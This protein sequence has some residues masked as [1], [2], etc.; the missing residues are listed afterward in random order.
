MKIHELLATPDQFCREH[1]A[2]DY[3]GVIIPPTCDTAVKWSIVGAAIKCYGG[4]DSVNNAV[5]DVLLTIQVEAGC[6]SIWDYTATV[7]FDDLQY[8]LKHLDV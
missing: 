2:L 8:L 7:H 6:L 3:Y 1:Y 4:G 5:D